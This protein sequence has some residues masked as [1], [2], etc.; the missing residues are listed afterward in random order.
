M[1]RVETLLVKFR[2]LVTSSFPP[3]SSRRVF[4]V[5]VASS[6]AVSDKV[7]AT[8]V[9]PAV[10]AREVVNGS[11]FTAPVPA[12]IAP[13]RFITL[14]LTTTSVFVTARVDSMSRPAVEVEASKTMF[15]LP[16]E[17][18]APVLRTGESFVTEPDLVDV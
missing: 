2:S 18:N 9:P 8:S 14:A 1:T 7:P 16:V 3:V 15:T 10:M 6:T 12:F 5:I 17:E 4:A 11:N 13:V